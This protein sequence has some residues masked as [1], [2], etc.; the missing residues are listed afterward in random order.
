MPCCFKKTI[1]FSQK[2]IR[3]HTSS[4]KLIFFLIE[5]N[6]KAVELSQFLKKE[7]FAI[8]SIKYYFNPVFNTAGEGSKRAKI[9][10][11]NSWCLIGETEANHW[12]L[13][14]W[15]CRNNTSYIGKIC[16]VFSG[17]F[18]NCNLRLTS[19]LQPVQS[20]T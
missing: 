14:K 13:V 6:H 7:K 17:L 5:N 20:L 2:K 19:I 11:T 3:Y 18:Q 16:L 9:R 15:Q 10:K 1:L 8:L 12:I 4:Q